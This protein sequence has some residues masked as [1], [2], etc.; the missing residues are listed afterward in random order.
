MGTDVPGTNIG[1]DIGGAIFG[2]VT[3][4]GSGEPITEVIVKAASTID[5]W[6]DAVPVDELG[7]FRL[8]GLLS[9][10]CDCNDRA[11]GIRCISSPG[12]PTC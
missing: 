11:I 10:I 5:W 4:D 9:D 3:D 2:Q 12:R 8:G 7:T 6:V 1:L